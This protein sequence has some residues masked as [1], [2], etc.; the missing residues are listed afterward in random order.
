MKHPSLAVPECLSPT[1]GLAATFF[2]LVMGIASPARA[3]T[4]GLAPLDPPMAVNQ[5]VMTVQQSGAPQVAAN[6]KVRSVTINLRRI[7][8]CDGHVTLKTCFVGVDVT[9]KKKVVNSKFVK[10]AEAVPG[11]GNE[12]TETSASFVYNPPSEDPKTKKPIPASGTKPSG[13]VVRVYQGDKLLT[14]TASTPELIPW[15]STQGD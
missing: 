5:L 13:W 11:K 1:L 12:Y 3:E 6:T 4:A 8:R 15:L 10:E 9:T 7:G 2:A 14:A